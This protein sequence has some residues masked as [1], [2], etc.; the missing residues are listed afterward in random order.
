MDW[1]RSKHS[2]DEKYILLVVKP[3]GKKQTV[4]PRDRWED[5]FKLV[6]KKA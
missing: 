6:L 3:E 4:R 1:E 5:I 2:R